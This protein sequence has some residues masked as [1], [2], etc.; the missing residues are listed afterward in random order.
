MSSIRSDAAKTGFLLDNDGVNY[1]RCE[2]SEVN[3]AG[4]SVDAIVVEL[5]NPHVN[6][7]LMKTYHLLELGGYGP[8]VLDETD[9]GNLLLK[10][11][12]YSQLNSEE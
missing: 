4:E 8:P 10:G 1:S 3:H 7:A 11:I 12:N 2:V 9:A 5:P 6:D